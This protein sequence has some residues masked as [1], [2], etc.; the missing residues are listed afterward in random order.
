MIKKGPSKMEFERLLGKEKI[1]REYFGKTFI[2]IIFS[3][4]FKLV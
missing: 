2:I 1:K 4:F 3:S